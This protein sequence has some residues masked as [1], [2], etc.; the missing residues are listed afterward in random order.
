[1]LL[2]HIT[3]RHELDQAKSSGYYLPKGFTT[4]GFI[5]CSYGHQVL[6]TAN[7]IFQ[8]C[9]DLVLLEIDPSA[10]ADPVVDENLEGGTQLFPH[11][12]GALPLASVLRVHD[13]PCD[14]DGQFQ[15][16]PTLLPRS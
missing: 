1:M 7:R 10:L 3:T 2:F 4:E 8:G 9:S 15:A 6:A 13:F 14:A 12:Y 11:L 5:H 16:P